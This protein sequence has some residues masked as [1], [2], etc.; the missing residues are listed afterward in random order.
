MT[1]EP[2]AADQAGAH[3]HM[4]DKAPDPLEIVCSEPSKDRSPGL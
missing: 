1:T 4:C 2:C 3:R